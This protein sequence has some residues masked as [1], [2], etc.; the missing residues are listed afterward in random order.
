MSTTADLKQLPEC[1]PYKPATVEELRVRIFGSDTAVLTGR[2]T[3]NPPDRAPMPEA[4]FTSVW[5]KGADGAWEQVA[6]QATE[7]RQQQPAR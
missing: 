6:Y 5:V 7:I 4:R 1:K 3:I 2:I